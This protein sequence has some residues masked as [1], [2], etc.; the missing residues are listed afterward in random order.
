MEKHGLVGELSKEIYALYESGWNYGEL[1]DLF[2]KSGFPTTEKILTDIYYTERRIRDEL[3][4]RKGITET[5]DKV[6]DPMILS[7]RETLVN[8]LIY[9][10]PPVD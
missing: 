5:H 3:I 8:A 10:L 4:A 2:G 7:M 1:V 6:T 9:K